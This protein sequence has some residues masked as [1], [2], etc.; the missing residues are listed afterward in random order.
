[1][2]TTEKTTEDLAREYFAAAAN[3]DVEE[4]VSKWAPGGI[5]VIYGMAE[6]DVP[7]GYRAYFTNL[8]D[9]FPDFRFEV[10]D[11]IASGN[12]AAVRWR[13][14]GTFNGEARFQGLTPNGARAEIEACDLLTFNGEGLATENRAYVNGADIAQKLGALPPP[15]SLAERGMLGAMNLKTAALGWVNRRR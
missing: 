9:A 2:A 8:F 13:G 14:T 15:D 12:Q 11:V 6:L 3:R 1:M 7:A 5:A 4:M 10:L